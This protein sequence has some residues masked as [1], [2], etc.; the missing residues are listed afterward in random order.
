[1][2]AVKKNAAQ[3]YVDRLPPEIVPP[4]APDEGAE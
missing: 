1:M 2:G 3:R 4:V